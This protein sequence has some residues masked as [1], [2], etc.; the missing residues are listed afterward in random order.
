MQMFALVNVLL[1]TYER[2][3]GEE[4]RGEAGRE[5]V[6]QIIPKEH[7]TLTESTC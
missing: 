2:G 5:G 6:L 3:S 4:E 1:V 7:N